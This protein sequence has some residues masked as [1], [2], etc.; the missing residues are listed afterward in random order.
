M[1]GAHPSIRW[2]QCGAASGATNMAIDEA[3]LETVRRDGHPILR[4]YTWDPPTLSL[5][6]GQDLAGIDLERCRQLGVGVVRRPTGGRAVL[7]WEELTY[8][9]LSLPPDGDDSIQQTYQAVGLSLQNGL[10]RFGIDVDLSR[11][12]VGSGHRAACFAST[13]RSEITIGGRKLVGSAQRRISGALLQH[14]S[15]LVGGA[16]L[17][18]AQIVEGESVESI[19]ASAIHLDEVSPSVDLNLLAERVAEGFAQQFASDLVLT[20][21]SDGE[22]IRAEELERTKYATHDHLYRTRRAV[23]A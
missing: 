11:G 4:T 23:P 3:L 21:L 15:L 9:F 19:T 12:R 10:Q 20:E 16:H 2:V 6:Y 5:G 17:L 7:H 1:S 8:C 18:L 22:L 13:S 14:G